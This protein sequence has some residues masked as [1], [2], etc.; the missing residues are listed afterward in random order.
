MNRRPRTGEPRKVRQ[1][2][3]IDKLPTEW[4]NRIIAFRDKWVT[5]EKLEKE[6]TT[7]EWDKLSSEQRA[8]FPKNRIPH[9]TLH[10][11][12]DIRIEQIRATRPENLIPRILGAVAGAKHQDKLT[13]LRAATEQLEGEAGGQRSGQ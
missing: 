1:P 13:A 2:L 8:L 12:Y 3:S 11:W 10:R 5:W 4:R 6:T 7:W 9:T